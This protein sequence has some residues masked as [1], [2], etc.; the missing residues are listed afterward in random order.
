[1]VVL[2]LISMV[3][4]LSLGAFYIP[5]KDIWL[6]IAQKFGFMKSQPIEELYVGVIDLVRW[7]R[8]LLGVLVGAALGISGASIQSIFR[9]PLAEPGLIGVSAGA[10][11]FAASII[12]FEGLLFV[13]LGQLFGH[14]LLAFGAFLGAGLS[15]WLVYKISLYEGKPHIGTMLLAG[16][17]INALAG[18]LTGLVSFMSDEQQ[19]RSITFW[20]LGSLGGANWN[21]V[22]TLLPFVLIA[23]IALPL[24]AK[25]LNTFSLGESEAHQLGQKPNTVKLRV[26]ILATMAVGAA[27]SVSGIIG[28]V[29]LLVPHAVRML[30][31]ADNRF[32][33]P[34]SALLGSIILT[35]ADLIARTIVIPSE[36]PIGVVTALLGTPLFLY[37]LIR[38]K[39]KIIV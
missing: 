4:S 20:M 19:L 28:F 39:K 6:S 18:S 37:I 1:M 7:P 8:T 21:T 3:L 11:L 15:T 38:D 34:A 9:N 30:G 32:V 27:V 5:L 14:Y 24:S 13:S 36:I 12:A 16:V 26:I 35:I 29:G 25:A 31:G 17:A 33:L 10:S 22:F 2:L 23:L